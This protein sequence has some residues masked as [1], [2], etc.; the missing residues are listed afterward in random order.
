MTEK[1]I[2]YVM[3]RLLSDMRTKNLTILGFRDRRHGHLRYV[4]SNNE[5]VHPQTFKAMRERDLLEQIEPTE[6]ANEQGEVHYRLK[7]GL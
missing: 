7:T 1:W 5:I 3:Q 4:L 2:S 6:V